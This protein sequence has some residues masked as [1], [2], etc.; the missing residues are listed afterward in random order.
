MTAGRRR[1]KSLLLAVAILFATSASLHTPPS[2]ANTATPVSSTTTAD[3]IVSDYVERHLF[4]GPAAGHYDAF[5]SA[6]EEALVDARTEGN[7]VQDVLRQEGILAPAKKSATGAAE[8]TTSRFLSRTAI[9]DAIVDFCQQNL[10]LN[11]KA[12]RAVLA[13]STVLV[14]PVATIYTFLFAGGAMRKGLMSKEKKTY[15]TMRDLTAV[16][17]EPED[18][19]EDDDAS[20][21]EDEEDE[22]DNDE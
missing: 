16:E 13:I 9:S 20:T 4:D 21:D 1:L 18:E 11:P 7:P 17:K 2:Y 6:Y 19:E 14:L 8:K 5:E 15:G 10:G 3:K 12:V 22:D